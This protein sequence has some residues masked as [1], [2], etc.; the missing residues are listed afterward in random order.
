M[1]FDVNVFNKSY[2]NAQEIANMVQE[3]ADAIEDLEKEND[4]LKTDIEEANDAYQELEGEVERLEDELKSLQM[5]LE[6]KED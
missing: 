2:V 3:M 5:S 1:S 6:D 4:R